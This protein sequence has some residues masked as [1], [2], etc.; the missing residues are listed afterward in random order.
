MGA[1]ALLGL[2]VRI[3]SDMRATQVWWVSMHR[4]SSLYAPMLEEEFLS[5]RREWIARLFANRN[6]HHPRTIDGKAHN[7]VTNSLLLSADGNSPEN[8]Q[9][10]Y[11]CITRA[12]EEVTLNKGKAR[13]AR[14]ERITKM[15]NKRNQT[16]TEVKQGTTTTSLAMHE[17]ISA[18]DLAN[19]LAP[20]YT[21]CATTYN[22]DVGC[23]ATIVREYSPPNVT[24]MDKQSSKQGY[25]IKI[26]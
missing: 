18:N 10:M 23:S 24:E 3:S 2:C 5:A 16:H 21:S 6:Q 7:Q 15:S 26:K 12:E 9:A 20:D 1:Y 13:V 25:T 19:C 11:L 22:L 4:A 17:P 14:L 8:K